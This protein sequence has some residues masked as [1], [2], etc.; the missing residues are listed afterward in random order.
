MFLYN[1]TLIRT[2]G[3]APHGVWGQLQFNNGPNR[4]WGYQN[5]ILIMQGPISGGGLYANEAAPN[6]PIDFTHN[7]W[8]PDGQIWWTN[9]G[10]A[11]ANL[12]A[13]YRGLPTR[14]P[15][16]SSATRRHEQDNITDSS[17]WTQR[18]ELGSDYHS[19]I[20]GPY[21][22]TL[23]GGSAPKNSG[24]VIPNITDGFSGGAPDRGAVIAGRPAVVYGER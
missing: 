1:N 12:A 16:F 22:P 5:N 17:P 7:S 9:S 4:S 20:E 19:E 10:G 24:I 11:F 21:L 3:S 23:S 18:I 6:D 8:Y 13:A 14:T 15:I 2:A